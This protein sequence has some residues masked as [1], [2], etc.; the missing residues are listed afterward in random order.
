MLCLAGVLRDLGG[1]N[2]SDGCDQA[3]LSFRGVLRSSAAGNELDIGWKAASAC[4]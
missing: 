4:V 3:R 1:I 2:V